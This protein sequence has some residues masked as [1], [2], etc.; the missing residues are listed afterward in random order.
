MSDLRINI[1]GGKGIL[2][3]PK[4]SRAFNLN[5]EHIVNIVK[6]KGKSKTIKAINSI[7]GNYENDEWADNALSW[8]SADFI[9]DSIADSLVPIVAKTEYG[10]FFS[11]YSKI[12]RMLKKGFKKAK[13]ERKAKLTKA[14]RNAI[15][16]MK[17][18][19]TLLE[20]ES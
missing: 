2:E 7:R 18:L 3:I 10:E 19:L 14:S 8:I 17:N 20:T 13:G 9:S 1:C 11:L 4:G 16:S 15:K 5:R 6:K 12:S